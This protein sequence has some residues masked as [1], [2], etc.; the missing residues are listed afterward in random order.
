MPTSP[1]PSAL[2][3]RYKYTRSARI[4][5]ETTIEAP[6]GRKRKIECDRLFQKVLHLE[7]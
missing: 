7:P 6:Y 3:R 4:E 1:F 5:Q 2:S